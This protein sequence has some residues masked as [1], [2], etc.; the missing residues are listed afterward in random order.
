[1]AERDTAAAA[2][3]AVVVEV[4][5]EELEHGR[6]RAELRANGTLHVTRVLEGKQD[7]FEHKVG[8]EEAGETIRRADALARLA[9]MRDRGY[10]PVPDEALYRIELVNAGESPIVVEVWQNELDEHEEARRLVQQLGEQVERASDG[11]AIL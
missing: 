8:A 11:R 5:N 10:R 6:V 7:L 9:P 3:D 1:M 2:S 4:G